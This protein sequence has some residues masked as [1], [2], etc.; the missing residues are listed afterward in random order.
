MSTSLVEDHDR[1]R[2]R[3]CAE[4]F[5]NIYSMLQTTIEIPTTEIESIARR[6]FEAMQ[7]T[8]SS[9]KDQE[10]L[11]TR[12]RLERIN[13]KEFITIKEAAFL[14]SCSRGHVDNLLGK[15][16]AGKT[17]NPVPFRD[18]DGL[19]VFNREELLA[20]SQKLKASRKR[21]KSLKFATV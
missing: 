2:S 3:I 5:E 15:A 17:T 1:P 9:D 16:R 6:V 12:Q 19:V 18:L 13:A 7:E 14:L 20:W 11:E 8:R 10:A 21:R 4:N